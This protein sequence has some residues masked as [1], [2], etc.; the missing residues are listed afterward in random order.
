MTRD[1][2]RLKKIKNW[3]KPR[4]AVLFVEVGNIFIIF[5]DDEARN[6]STLNH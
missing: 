4:K 5:L 1:W 2:K 6:S 3:G